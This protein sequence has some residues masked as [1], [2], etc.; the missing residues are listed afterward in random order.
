MI[1]EVCT[2]TLAS[3]IIAERAGADRIELCADL[4]VGG[5]TPSA[6][7]IKQVK[8]QVAIPIAVMIRPRAGDFCYSDAELQTMKA[9]IL[10]AKECGA[11]SVV[12]GVLTPEGHID[13][14]SMAELIELSRPMEVACHRAFD[15]TKDAYHSLETLIELGVDR[16]LTGGFANKAPEGIQTIKS[17]V[18]HSNGKIAIMPGSGINV[19]NLPHFIEVTGAT[20]YHLSGK[21]AIESLMIY[22]KK[23]ISMG[24]ASNNEY[25]IEQAD[26]CKIHE[27]AALLKDS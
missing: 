15:M 27:I 9:D 24:A 25:L 14:T 16:L 6:G 12:F 2:D 22:R 17:L 4:C 1:L 23:G 18:E 10:F 5:T 7:L 3:T 26:Y 20:E 13:K 21:H 11:E 8:E 19:E